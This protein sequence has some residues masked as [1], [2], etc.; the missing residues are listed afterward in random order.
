LGSK[1]IENYEKGKGSH[2]YDKFT[3]C[4]M[5]RQMYDIVMLAGEFENKERLVELLE[6]AFLMGIKLVDKLA[7][8]KLQYKFLSPSEKMTDAEEAVRLRQ[9]RVNLQKEKDRA[10]GNRLRP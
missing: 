5:H 2:V 3:I 7:E 1:V 9:L 10:V 8:Y 4:E 6:K